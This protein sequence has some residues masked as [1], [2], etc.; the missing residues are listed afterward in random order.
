[1]RMGNP[2]GCKNPPPPPQVK[3]CCYT[4]QSHRL[5]YE[6][7]RADLPTTPLTRRSH[8]ALQR[9]VIMCMQGGEV[10][11]NLFFGDDQASQ[12]NNTRWMIA[13]HLASGKVP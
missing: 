7:A 2:Q 11:Q 9:T 3:W 5:D 1:M 4:W 6:T 8:D 13:V 10:G 12:D